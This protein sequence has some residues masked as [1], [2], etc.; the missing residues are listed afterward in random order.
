M[1]VPEFEG[2][3]EEMGVPLVYVAEMVVYAREL[4]EISLTTMVR[5]FVVI[6]PLFAAVIL[7]GADAFTDVGVPEIIPL[8]V[9]SVRP[10]G[11]DGFTE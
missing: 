2:E 3:F 4:G 10:V 1:A 7:Y 8:V 9:F 6:P 5:V 11:S